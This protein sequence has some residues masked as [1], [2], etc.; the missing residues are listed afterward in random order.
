MERETSGPEVIRTYSP[1][2]WMRECFLTAR[3]TPG[4]RWP[5]DY[6][7]TAFSTSPTSLILTTSPVRGAWII[8]PPPM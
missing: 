7:L 6:G 3:R 4:W 2:V 5:M 1:R 8:F